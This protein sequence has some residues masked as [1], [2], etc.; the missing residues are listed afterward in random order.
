MKAQA[1]LKPTT[2]SLFDDR[3]FVIAVEEETGP[4][5]DLFPVA[6]AAHLSTRG[7]P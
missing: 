7:K 6:A 1:A 2:D 4:D 5:R 3:T